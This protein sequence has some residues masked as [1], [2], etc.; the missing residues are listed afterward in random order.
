MGF[1]NSESI[2]M[3]LRTAGIFWKPRQFY[4]RITS[5]EINKTP[6]DLLG[7][8]SV[9]L[10]VMIWKLFSQW[11]QMT[12]GLPCSEMAMWVNISHLNKLDQFRSEERINVDIWFL[13]LNLVWGQWHTKHSFMPFLFLGSIC[14]FRA[15]P[16]KV[17]TLN[18]IIDVVRLPLFSTCFWT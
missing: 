14:S 13:V 8:G 1:A 12:A 10:T 6:L 3:V 16:R 7:R 5:P 15:W 4:R 2:Y 9:M 17:P 18:S 11:V